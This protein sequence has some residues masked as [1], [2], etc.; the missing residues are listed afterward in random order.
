MEDLKVFMKNILTGKDNMTY[1]LG[2]VL[3]AIS[4][5]IGVVA[6]V[7][8]QAFGREFNLTD[9]GLGVGGLLTAGALSLKLKETTEPKAPEASD[10]PAGN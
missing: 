10:E 2:R 9:F 1:D 7:L 6:D 8:C 4:F 5:S 3:W